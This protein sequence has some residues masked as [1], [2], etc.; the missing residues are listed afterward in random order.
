MGNSSGHRAKVIAVGQHE[1]IKR[2]AAMMLDHNVGCLIVND[3]EGNF[4]GLITERDIAHYVAESPENV[5]TTYVSRIMVRDVIS[6]APGTPASVAR[7]IMTAHHI[8]HLPIMESGAV[9]GILSSRDVLDQQLL[10]DRAAAREVAMLSKCLKSIDL[11]EA[12]E[13]VTIE[14]PKLFDAKN[15]ALCLYPDNG[16]PA[17]EPE[18]TASNRC[19]CLEGGSPQAGHALWTFRAD[20]PTPEDGGAVAEEIRIEQTIARECLANGGQAPRVVIPLDITGLREGSGEEP[21]R[22]FGCLCMCGLVRSGMFNQELLSY[23]AKLTQ[24][25]AVPAG[26]TDFHDRYPDRGRFP[27][28]SG[29]QA[30]GGVHPRPTIQAAV[31]RRD[32]RPGPLQDDQRRPGP[33]HR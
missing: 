32:H 31:L 23:K 12:A 14:A 28:A 7:E 3:D 30:P 2:A 21:K 4:A 33:C 8:R 27:A 9:V 16:K 6:C 10:E 11:N 18:L 5:A 29:G 26:A 13:I 24:R 22:L 1:T 17:E 15:C 25:H 19:P 20:R